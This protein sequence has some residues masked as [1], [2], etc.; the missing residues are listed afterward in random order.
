MRHSKAALARFAFVAV[1]ITATL[2]LTRLAAQYL[3]YDSIRASPNYAS[4]TPGL[5]FAE[6]HK[7]FTETDQQLRHQEIRV[8]LP[9]ARLVCLV[10]L[11]ANPTIQVIG[12]ISGLV[13][14]RWGRGTAQSYREHL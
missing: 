12:L 3:V 10:G 2:F 6:V 13:G 14:S 8:D 5:T 9:F 7:H 4:N 1:S 11:V